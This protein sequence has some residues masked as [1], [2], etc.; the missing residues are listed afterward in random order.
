MVSPTAFNVWA[1]FGLLDGPTGC[2]PAFCVVRF[3]F[4]ML[5]RYLAYRPG[6]VGRVY[7]LLGDGRVRVVLGMVL[8]IFFLQVLLKLGFGGIQMPLLGLGL[9]CFFLVICLV[10]FSIL[11]LL[12]LMFGVKRSLLT[13]VVVRVFVVGL[14]L[15]SMAL[16]SSLILL[17]FG[18]EKR[19]CF[20]TSWLGGV[21]NGGLLGR[22]RSQVVACRFCGAP[23]G[24]GHLFWECTFS[25]S[26]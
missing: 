16:C 11:R 5:R 24:D 20:V 18:K 9:A 3:R 12:F 6:E 26:C 7:R 15:I 17:M 8:F 2:D 25:S 10:L 1:V 22:V 14:C 23:D 4:R 13:F 21:W 19:R